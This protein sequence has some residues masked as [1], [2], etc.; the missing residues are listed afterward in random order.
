MRTF[1]RR[2]L[3]LELGLE[4][5]IE[6]DF[7]V[8]DC[9]DPIIGADLIFQHGLVVDLRNRVLQKTQA[10]GIISV[11]LHSS[12]RSATPDPTPST[13]SSPLSSLSPTCSF[14]SDILQEY[15]ALLEPISLDNLARPIDGQFFRID[16]GSAQPVTARFRRLAPDKQKIVEAHFEKLQALGLVRPSRSPWASPLH[17]V[18]KADGDWRPTGDYR[19]L[20]LVTVPDSYPLPNTNDLRNELYGAKYFTKIDLQHGFHHVRVHPDDIEK[21]AVITPFGLFEY[22]VMGF[23]FRNAPQMF[24]RYM[25]AVLKGLANAYCYIDDILIANEYLDEHERDVRRVLQRLCEYQLHVNAG[26]SEF[27]RS[28]VLFLGNVLSANDIRPAPD[29]VTAISETPLPE[30]QKQLRRFV[31][32]INYHRPNLPRLAEHLAPLNGLNRRKAKTVAWTPDTVEAFYRARDSI[33]EFCALTFLSDVGSLRLTTDASNTA[34]GGVLEQLQ[35]ETWR[36]LGFYSKK[37]AGPETRYS[38]FDKELL[39]IYRSLCHFRHLVQGRTDFHILTDHKPLISAL[40]KRIDAPNERQLR[41]LDLIAQF[42]SDIRYLKGL[43]NPVADFLS[44]KDEPPEDDPDPDEAA[45]VEA[46]FLAS[47]LTHNTNAVISLPFTGDEVCDF[48]A[49]Q[50]NDELRRLKA[51]PNAKWMKLPCSNVDHV[52]IWCEISLPNPRVYVPERFRV[53]CFNNVHDLAH[54]GQRATAKLMQERYLWTGISRDV[55]R[56]VTDCRSCAIHKVVRHARPL[57]G[58]FDPVSFKF[59]HVHLDIVGPFPPARGHRYVLTFID[60]FSR[61]VEAVPLRSITAATCAIE[62][63]RTWIARFGAPAVITTDRGTQFTSELFR[64]LTHLLGSHH[65]TTTAYHPQS[66]GMIERFHRVMNDAIACVLDRNRTADW[67]RALPLILLSHR[68]T[69]RDDLAAS[70]ADLVYGTPL[71]LPAD[72]IIREPRPITKPTEAFVLDFFEQMRNLPETAPRPQAP[73]ASLSENLK[74]AAWVYVRLDT[75]TGKLQPRYEGP[76]RVLRKIND[77]VYEILT[78]HGVDTVS[79][80]RLKPASLPQ[81]AALVSVSVESPPHRRLAL[82]SRPSSLRRPFAVGQTGSG[83]E[84]QRATGH[85]K[86]V[87]WAMPLVTI[88]QF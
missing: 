87:R 7:V 31:G 88:K 11:V 73:T 16:T 17:L 36:P 26:K 47:V 60:R 23:G 83:R 22:T 1:G 58:S 67:A 81:P 72:F 49:G 38:T 54:P 46:V 32:M 19:P 52:D 15:P 33:T 82:V 21:T 79:T 75:H 25:D 45:R 9:R 56:W 39:A 37:L 44:R 14:P 18:P 41:H 28:S 65:I 74:D 50:Q 6:W 62:L 63:V 86:T 2:I 30:T 85:T 76:C 43:D 53:R 12:L 51:T 59:Q 77:N 29:K 64:E 8:A 4:T 78:S 84:G 66:N 35:Q 34:I 40:A 27:C 24:Q 48:S 55:K 5:P 80:E 69:P 71:S 70:P 68:T 42:T 61:W 20:N 3:T 57:P 10:E 13:S